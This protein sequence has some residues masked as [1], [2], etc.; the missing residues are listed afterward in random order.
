MPF[1][2]EAQR[3]YLWSKHPQITERWAHEYPHQ[4]HLPRHARGKKKHH[5]RASDLDQFLQIAPGEFATPLAACPTS[6]F[7]DTRAA[8]L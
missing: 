4:G 3:R 2:S 8:L 5:K 7:F 1:K 6:F